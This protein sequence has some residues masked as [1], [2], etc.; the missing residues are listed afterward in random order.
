MNRMKAWLIIA[1]WW[2]Q[3][4]L[5]RIH[6]YH[7]TTDPA[8]VHHRA[9]RAGSRLD[10][11]SRGLECE[12]CMVRRAFAHHEIFTTPKGGNR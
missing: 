4:G 10:R 8:C 5:D 1:S 12:P 6:R 2:I 3:G 9:P 11:A 7:L